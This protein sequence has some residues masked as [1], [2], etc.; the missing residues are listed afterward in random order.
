MKGLCAGILFVV[1]SLCAGGC[2]VTMGR[3]VTNISS[4]APGTISVERCELQRDTW[5]GQ[6]QVTDCETSPVGIGQ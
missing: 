5:T 4:G 6:F 3:F 1:L 2:A